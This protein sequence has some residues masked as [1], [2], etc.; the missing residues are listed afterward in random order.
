M[1][2]IL[3]WLATARTRVSGTNGSQDIMV[4]EE[5]RGLYVEC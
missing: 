1:K 4:L 3:T 5:E 2:R